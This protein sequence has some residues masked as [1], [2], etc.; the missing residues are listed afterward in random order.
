[1]TNETYQKLVAALPIGYAYHRIIRNKKN[2]AVDFEFLDI[3][4]EF[5]VITGLSRDQVTGKRSSEIYFGEENLLEKGASFYQQ[6]LSDKITAELSFEYRREKDERYY[7]LRVVFS[8]VDHFAILIKDQTAEKKLMNQLSEEEENLNRFF[9]MGLDLF[10]VIDLTGRF[11][12]VNKAWERTLGY[13]IDDLRGNFFQNYLNPNDLPKTRAMMDELRGNRTEI[14]WF[15]NRYRRKDGAYRWLEWNSKQYGDHIYGAARDITDRLEVETKLAIQN[16]R[17]ELAVAGSNDGIWDWDI[18][19][20][21]LYLSPRYKEQLGYRADELENALSVVRELIHPDDRLIFDEALTGYLQGLYQY[22]DLE[23]RMLHKDGGIV[24]IRSRG[25][26][27][28]DEKGKIHRMAGSHSDITKRKLDE[29]ALRNSEE[30]YRLIAENMSD[31]IWVYK[32]SCNQITYMSPSIRGISG[33]DPDDLEGRPL[34]ASLAPQEEQQLQAF[35]ENSKAAFLA[36]PE[37]STTYLAE[38]QQ[39]HKN[40]H[41]FW[42]EQ[43]LRFYYD[44]NGDLEVYGIARNIDERKKAENLSY[45]DQ[46]TGL[47]NRHFF[48]NLVY[49]EIEQADRYQDDL[50]MVLLDLDFFKRVNDTYGHPIGDEVLK[51]TAHMVSGVIRKADIFVRF[52]GEEFIV[53]MPRTD[54]QGAALVAEKIRKTM[55]ENSH[56]VVGRQTVSIGIAQR[57]EHETFPHW[58]QRV[59]EALYKAKQNGRNCAI[60]AN[61][62]ITKKEMLVKH[63]W[64]NEWDSGNPFIDGQHRELNDY[65]NLLIEQILEN[66]PRHQIDKALDSFLN[67]VQKHF[68]DEEK[69]LDSRHYPQLNEHREI[70][71]FLLDKANRLNKS[72]R[73]GTVSPSIFFSFI[74]DDVLRNHLQ[75]EDRKFYPYVKMNHQQ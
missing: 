75:K 47:Y 69:I 36:N 24:W 32:Y 21:N 61:H 45:R 4:E 15:V 35:V 30:K 7:Q 49:Q 22:F 54:W 60:V 73:E 51:Y 46:L 56:Q 70:H 14:R 6:I 18:V 62:T 10:C 65:C 74:V 1:M 53:L 3:N 40:G 63:H 64:R 12:L 58:Y 37:K 41:I 55:S 43:S 20:D 68:S 17:F 59:D 11:I 50:S 67:F 27:L 8:E 39:R 44:V 13:D 48:D 38:F 31:A 5:A 52:G 72:Y 26:G 28:K 25:A 66:E 23:F 19:N 33:Y 29:E 16:E 2:Q 9:E 71:Q 42:I 57:L 34:G